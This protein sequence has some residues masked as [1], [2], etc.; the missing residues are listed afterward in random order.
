[1]PGADRVRHIGVD[2]GEDALRRLAEAEAELD[3]KPAD[4]AVQ[5]GDGVT[6]ADY[7]GVAITGSAL[8]VYDG[9]AH[10]TRQVELVRAVLETDALLLIREYIDG[11]LFDYTSFA[12]F[13]DL[14]EKRDGAW[15]IFE[16]SC[17]YDKDRL[18]PVVPAW[19]ASGV[20]AQVVLEGADTGFAF[21]KL[22]QAKR[23]RTIPETVVVCDTEAEHA[24]RQRGQ[25]WLAGKV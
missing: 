1:M 21:M 5:L 10:I 2:D 9:G 25:N 24:L 13:Y 12:R 19:D 20:Y 11:A 6:L 17:I 8:N 3:C 7:D 22:R 15:R 4:G 18:D 23:G 16:W 14:F